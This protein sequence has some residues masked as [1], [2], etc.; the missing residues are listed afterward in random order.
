[1]RFVKFLPVCLV[2]LALSLGACAKDDEAEDELSPADT[3]MTMPPPA[4]D[5]MGDTMMMGDTT[6]MGDSMQ[7]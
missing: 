1:M 5:M 3:A 6:M 2:A 7:M 4:P